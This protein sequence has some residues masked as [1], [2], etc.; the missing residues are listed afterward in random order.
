MS[1]RTR[2]TARS[3]CL[4][5][6]AVLAAALPSCMT[7]GPDYEPPEVAAPDAW[8]NAALEGFHTGDSVLHS[9]WTTLED[10]V[11]DDLIRRSQERNR[12]L[13]AA[14]ARIVQ[15]AALRGVAAG[16]R[17]PDIDAGASAERVRFSNDFLSQVSN[18]E[19]TA[20]MY[21][22]GVG[23]F[24]EADLWGRVSRS[25]EAADA[26]L[27]RQVE[28][29][30]DLMVILFAQV[31]IAYVEVRALQT[32]VALAEQNIER[33]AST[34]EITRNRV[35]AGLAPELDRHQAE[36][37][38]G[39][40]ESTL[41]ALRAALARSTHRLAVLVGEQPAAL[42]ELLG[43]PQPVPAAAEGVAV[44][45]P[46]ELLRQRPDVRA[47]EREL[48]RLT[49]EI[50]VATAAKYPTVGLNGVLGL[51]GT[52]GLLDADNGIFSIGASAVWNLFDGGRVQG[53]ID[54]REAQAREALV[55]YEQTVLL[56]L[57]EVESALV[58]YAE[59][60][61]RFAALDRSTAAAERSVELVHELYTTGLTDFQNVLD[62]ERFLFEQQDRRAESEGLLTQYLIAVY[63]SLGG[64]WDVEDARA[65]D[66][67]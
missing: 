47:A 40:T 46:A 52:S 16:E 26:R 43:E 15:A 4:P 21:T 48:A 42:N 66:L 67:P 55:N 13:E 12:D 63:R 28:N 61:E 64:G 33:Q 62:T 34:V 10:P 57:E 54:F 58:T 31:G 25:I 7:V 45:L 35:D 49:A 32:R 22:V 36:F 60:R 30:R 29:Y 41:P 39:N 17:Y 8:E 24:W 20:N 3:T 27:D 19:R 50:G 44:A 11:L 6:L 2:S 9:W 37:N 56:A 1:A 53:T 5:V 18:G 23:G 59:E 65:D 14:H 51:G 38:L